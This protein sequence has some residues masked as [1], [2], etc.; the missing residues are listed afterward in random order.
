M[1]RVKRFVVPALLLA[2]ML[3]AVVPSH[4]VRRVSLT[5]RYEGSLTYNQ[6][7]SRTD[8]TCDAKGKN[9]KLASDGK[10]EFGKIK[11]P[12]IGGSGKA[13]DMTFK[14]VD[15]YDIMGSLSVSAC[16]DKNGNGSCFSDDDYPIYYGCIRN[17]ATVKLRG[18]RRS[19][20]VL[21]YVNAAYGCTRYAADVADSQ[22]MSTSGIVTLKY[23]L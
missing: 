7:Q 9:C 11:F 13:V 2:A 3:G 5:R 6:A 4:A 17:G 20:D 10:I 8:P 16:A 19:L 23:T 15:D 21:V 1:T 22:G 14:V 12:A 18:V